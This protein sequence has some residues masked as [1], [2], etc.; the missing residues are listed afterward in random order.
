M[1][2]ILPESV[3]K[4]T[5]KQQ[6]L[7]QNLFTEK[8]IIAAAEKAGYKTDSIPSNVYLMVRTPEFQRKML[9][10]AK[11]NNILDLPQIHRIEAQAL[12]DLER[13]PENYAKYKDILKQ[14]K[15]V[16]GLLA[17]D[18]QPV[19]ATVSIQSV[20]NMQ[21][22]VGDTVSDRLKKPGK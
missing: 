17:P 11:A 20:Q 12:N 5:P 14:K 10:Y 7:I 2:V 3:Q 4:L 19:Q 1:E 16:A 8:T 9:E 13:N 18:T 6:S 21:V 15:Q 22:V